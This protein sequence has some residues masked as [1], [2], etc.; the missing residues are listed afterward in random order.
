MVETA[1]VLLCWAQ[2]G[3]SDPSVA[4]FIRGIQGGIRGSRLILGW[5]LAVFSTDSRLVFSTVFSS[6]SR[7]ILD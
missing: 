6:D 3:G 5:F 1:A 7:L 4:F 2:G